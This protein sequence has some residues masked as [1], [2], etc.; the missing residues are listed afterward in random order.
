MVAVVAIQSSNPKALTDKDLA[1]SDVG[2]SL[3]DMKERATFRR[4]RFPYLYDGDTGKVARAF[5]ATGH[6]C[7]VVWLPGR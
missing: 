7:G 2:D 1:W 5:G 4:F 3:D 6:R